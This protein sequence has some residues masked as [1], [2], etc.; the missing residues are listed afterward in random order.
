MSRGSEERPGLEMHV[1]GRPRV[2][3]NEGMGLGER[4]PET[5]SRAPRTQPRLLPTLGGQTGAGV[6]GA[7][8]TALRESR[9]R[10]LD[11]AE[12]QGS[13]PAEL[14]AAL[15]T[16]MTVTGAISLEWRFVRFIGS[17]KEPA[18]GYQDFFHIINFCMYLRLVELTD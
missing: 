9:G 12:P 14:I 10:L 11:A 1:W 16:K 2:R 4:A 5:Q 8:R 17:L 18:F 3:G 15:G 7:E 13:I 6:T